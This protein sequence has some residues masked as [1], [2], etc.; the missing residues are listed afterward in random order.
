MIYL[1]QGSEEYFIREKLAAIC[2]QDDYDI[3]RF[4]SSDKDLSMADIIDACSGNSLFAKGTIV[5]VRDP[6]FLSKKAD[7]KELE[8]L[9][10]YVHHPLYETELVFYTF[11]NNFNSKLKAYKLISENA[12]ILNFNSYDYKNFNN[13]VRS[14]LSEE[15]LNLDK[16]SVFYLTNL[17]KRS[18]TLLNQNIE[19]LK[20]YP[21]K[22]DKNAV[23]ALCST[24]D[25]NDS[26]ELINALTRRE[27]SKAIACEQK[28]FSQND[29]ILSI[30]GL[31]ANQLR[32]LYQIA[33]YQSKGKKKKEIME[34]T[35]ISDYRYSK[36]CE[37]LNT[38]NL[39]Q[40]MYLLKKLSELDIA[41]KSAS[42]IPD[43]LAL[44]LF[45]VN[46]SRNGLYENS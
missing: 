5:L 17:C 16:D 22:I 33:Y 1:L 9:A 41:C 30:V 26:F 20:L 32:F 3:I 27:V 34:L 24:G 8:I 39:E 4:D 40:I 23:A 12:Q 37:S 31:L 45:I 7:D 6:Y 36:A 11:A 28:M 46:L 19:I 10:D 21:D 44:E 14:R 13:Y 15:K 25:D 2:S 42:A 35:N 43:K 29:S 38:L 18:A